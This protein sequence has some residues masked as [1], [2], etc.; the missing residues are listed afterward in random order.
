[1]TTFALSLT[2]LP[3][4][5]LLR[6][7]IR[8]VSQGRIFP[9]PQHVFIG[10]LPTAMM[11]VKQRD[12]GAYIS[13]QRRHPEYPNPVDWYHGVQMGRLAATARVVDIIPWVN[14]GL[15]PF[16]LE[17]IRPNKYVVQFDDLQL[18]DEPIACKQQNGG[19]W[20]YDESSQERILYFP[21]TNPQ[22]RDFFDLCLKIEA[23]GNHVERSRQLIETHPGNFIFQKRYGKMRHE[24][25]LPRRFDH[26]ENPSLM[27][28]KWRQTFRR[29]FPEIWKEYRDSLQED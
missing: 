13:F 23:C 20:P 14:A 5:F 11:Y 26:K 29:R 7:E 21:V 10:G 4:D 16:E 2:P 22:L 9:Y 3:Y 15:T 18:L 24:I 1:M 12:V 8:H 19:I 28:R 25:F 17:I 27:L 6:G